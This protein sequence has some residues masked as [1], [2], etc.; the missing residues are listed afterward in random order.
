MPWGE[1]KLGFHFLQHL[2]GAVIFEVKFLQVDPIK[3]LT[4]AD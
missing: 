3:E 1:G 2:I 4:P